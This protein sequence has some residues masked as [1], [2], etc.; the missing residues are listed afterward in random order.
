M[1]ARLPVPGAGRP[2]APGVSMP[3]RRNAA[4]ATNMR[5]RPGVPMPQTTMVAK[6]KKKKRGSFQQVLS[7]MRLTPGYDSRQRRF[8]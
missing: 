7:S 3:A 4:V 2:A 6:N 8:G 5:Q 1:A